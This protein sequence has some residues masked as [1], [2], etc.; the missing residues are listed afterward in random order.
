MGDVGRGFF[1]RPGIPE[2]MRDRLVPYADII[3]PNQ[4][5]LEYLTGHT[6]MTIGDAM[7]A[8][9]AARAM[10]P[11]IVLI[12]SLLREDAAD[13]SRI[14]MLAVSGEGAWLVATPRL[15]LTVNG[16]GDAT[17][18]M[19]LGHYLRTGA[20]DTAL[21]R[22]A[23][24]IFTILEATQRAGTREIRLIEAQDVIAAPS[25]RFAVERLR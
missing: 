10:G 16:S 13:R 18:A 3:T 7:G 8:A 23:T 21:G 14:E 9:D 20:I 17:T 1:V 15:P 5:E 22:T 2:L 24:A 25:D 12:T 4:F 6:V 11:D 19:F